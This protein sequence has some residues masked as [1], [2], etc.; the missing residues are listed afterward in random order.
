MFAR[1]E[2]DSIESVCILHLGFPV[3]VTHGQMGTSA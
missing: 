2:L 3:D 1:L